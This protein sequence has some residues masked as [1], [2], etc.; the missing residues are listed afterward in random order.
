ME[1]HDVNGNTDEEHV[2]PPLAFAFGWSVGMKALLDA[3]ADP[4]FA[5]IL[6]LHN[7][8]DLALSL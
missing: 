6:A 4:F 3:S 1:G 2:S 8:D 7:K 5:L